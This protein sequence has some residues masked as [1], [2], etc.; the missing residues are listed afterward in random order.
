MSS[1]LAF[2]GKGENEA[3]W[4]AHAD[5][6]ILVIPACLPGLGIEVGKD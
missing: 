4:W 5:L 2:T 6:H 1:I 3:I